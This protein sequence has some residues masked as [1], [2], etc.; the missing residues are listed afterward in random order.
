MPIKA[1][2]CVSIRCDGCGKGHDEMYTTPKWEMENLRRYGWTGT[3]K[4]C[5]CPECSI[6]RMPPLYGKNEKEWP[7]EE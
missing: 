2:P 4:K 1:M 6:K 5:Y 7:K 3:Y